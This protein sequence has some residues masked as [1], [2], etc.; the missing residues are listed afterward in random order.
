MNEL[1]TLLRAIPRPAR[2][3][4]TFFSLSALAYAA[5][6][7]LGLGS[8][9]WI[10]AVVV[11]AFCFLYW[12]IEALRKGVQKKKSREFEGSLGLHSRKSEVGKEEIREALA[13]LSEKWQTSVAQLREAGMS[14]YSLPWYLLIGEPASGKTTTL[15]NS[16]LEFPVG[17]D[18]LSGSGGTRNCDWWFTN[19]AVILDTAGRFTFQEESAPDQQ[20]WSAFLKLL[21]KN[22]KYSPIN[23]AIVVIPATSL[24]EDPVDEQERKAK[25][26][27][28]KLLHLQKVL[29]IR[30]PI[31]ILVTKADRILGFTEFFSKLDPA[32]QRQL[33][34]WSNPGAPEEAWD[35]KSF[36]GVFDEIVDRSHK[37][38]MRFL[39]DEENVQLADK[40]FVFPEE[41]EALKEPLANY[42]HTVFTTSRFEEPFL[43]RGFYLTSGVQQGRPIAIACRDLLR[44]QVGDPQGVLEDLEQVFHKSRAFFIR[45]F[46]EKKLFPEQGLIARTRAAMKKDQ[47]FRWIMYG[48]SGGIGLLTLILLIFGSINLFHVVKPVSDSAHTANRCLGLD[49]QDKTPC[50]VGEAYKLVQDFETQKENVRE[51]KWTLRTFLHSAD[52]NEISASLIP[53]IQ[54]QL[55]ERNVLSPLLAS[56]AARTQG[57][58]LWEKQ[59]ND[60]VSFRDGLAQ[61]LRFKRLQGTTAGEDLTA[62]RGGLGIA[63]L[64][65]FCKAT[66]GRDPQGKEI[67]DWLKNNDVNL[68]QADKIFREAMANHPDLT[69]LK[70]PDPAGPHQAFRDYWT[71]HNVARWDALTDDYLRTYKQLYEEMLG[72]AGSAPPAVAPPA[73]APVAATAP[74]VA[75]GA[76]A[77]QVAPAAFQATP[78]VP[79]TSTASPP[80]AAAPGAPPITA[81]APALPAGATSVLNHFADLSQ[82]F[83]DNFAK[84]EA[85]MRSDRQ[86]LGAARPGPDAPA[87]DA[88][89]VADYSALIKISPLTTLADATA[90]CHAIPGQWTQL[91]QGRAQYAHLFQMRPEGTKTIM[92]W[93]ADAAR[94]KDPLVAL[95]TYAAPAQVTADEQAF[96]KQLTDPNGGAQQRL[97][98]LNSTYQSTM[99]R[100]MANVD[101]LSALATGQSAAAPP[102]AAP[103]P[104]T[105]PAAAPPS[106]TPPAQIAP[107]APAFRLAQGV[108]QARQVAS[109]A[110]ALRVLAP[111]AGFFTSAQAFGCTTCYNHQHA[112]DHVPPANELL[113]WAR[114]NL[115][116][117]LAE[118]KEVSS[119]LD[120]IDKAEYAYLEAYINQQ[121]WGGSGG[122]GGGGASAG[123]QSFVVPTRA[124]QTAAWRDFVRAIRSWEPVEERAGGGGGGAA[125]VAAPVVPA[126]GLTGEDLARYAARNDNL[127]PLLAVFNQ[128]SSAAQASAAV[129]AAAAARPPKPLSQ[130]L[131]TVAQSFKHCISGLEEDPLKAWRQLALE[132]DG[133]SLADFHSF[134]AN[135]RL[136][137]NPSA[138]RMIDVEKHGAQLLAQAIRPPFQ[139][140]LHTLWSLAG[141]CCGDRYP[142]ISRARL[143]GQQESYQRGPSAGGLWAPQGR[144]T[145]QR[146][147]SDAMNFDTVT[148]D[149]LDRLFFA[150]GSLDGLYSDFALDPI[151]DGRERDID[152]VGA[153]KDRL[154][155]LRQWQRF[156]YGE[157]HTT[158]AQTVKVK[159]LSG[160]NT[161]PR[162]F[163]GER[164]GQINLFGPHPVRPSTDAG[165]VHILSLPLVITA[166]A[167]EQIVGRN[168]DKSGGWSGILNLRGGPLKIPYF[169][170]VASDGRPREGGKV[171]TIHLQLPDYAQPQ[172]RLEGVFEFT[173]ERPLPEIIPGASIDGL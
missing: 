50:G 60:Y 51:A 37:Q 27:R 142:F 73:V 76:A 170:E 34:G 40:L 98:L 15:K 12:L 43:F 56:F 112:E 172:Q 30:F 173:F 66:P 160:A 100:G 161:A 167:Q 6:R 53:A 80:S 152:F 126:N 33:F 48:L 47:T 75:P 164:M 119:Y 148:L 59:G 137:G 61:L 3:L 163:I 57:A 97:T 104:G 118:D 154:R 82:R 120:Q 153:S 169:L 70:M 110:V 39:K 133:A 111:A 55:F 105:P 17:A 94:I 92:T 150:G 149:A 168:E 10:P 23:G 63:P 165:G 54:A 11:L 9:A 114:G 13:E 77:T 68:D 19:E 69:H 109:L 101:A 36:G 96:Q 18:A 88:N 116:A 117:A 64:L 127:K 84:G 124:S 71:I 162:I 65:A 1:M 31:F 103:A 157:G 67:D 62:I 44:V 95:G 151:V 32:E 24:V 136:R 14:I 147:V 134:S 79:T 87:W 130:D 46:Y 72:L 35:L 166:N 129:A 81:P 89:C 2:W 139:D 159:L 20:E 115:K 22:R 45:D 41:L 8:R 26:I 156:I 16:G 138:A 141:S 107:V 145:G 93:S 42:L 25:N 125:A 74:T 86:P 99:Q 121:R 91:T 135:L 132:K 58:D 122:G 155:V 85:H 143:A 113:Y 21:R 108:D 131:V 128:R 78:A 83:A 49:P 4:V 106:A 90:Y 5:G 29:E 7:L 52:R 144:D 146:S 38:R 123:G 158:A 102:P 28:Q 171:W 140:R